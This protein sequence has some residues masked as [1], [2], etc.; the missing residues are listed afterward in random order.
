MEK[1]N[2]LEILLKHENFKT[3]Q[4]QQQIEQKDP[5][6]YQRVS[7]IINDDNLETYDIIKYINRNYYCWKLNEYNRYLETIDKIR[8]NL[9]QNQYKN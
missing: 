5:L 1:L 3:T 8:I 4:K 2:Q 7:D 9:I 6:K